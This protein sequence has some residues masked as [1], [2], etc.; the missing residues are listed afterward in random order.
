M[1][2]HIP[3][4]IRQLIV[5][6]GDQLDIHSTVFKDYDPKCDVVWM[7]E[8]ASESNYVWSSKQRIVL[9]LSAMRHFRALLLGKKIHL[10]YTELGADD[11]KGSITEQLAFTLSREKIASVIA[12]EP[13]EYRLKGAI[14]HVCQE[15][16]VPLTWK[17]DEHFLCSHEQFRNH[18]ASRRQLRM[19]FFYREMRKRYNI[20]MEG[21]K[22][23]GGKWNF[24]AS[25]RKSFGEKG[26]GSLPKRDHFNPDKITKGVKKLVGKYFST[27]PGYLESFRWPVTREQALLALSNF[28]EGCLPQFGK[29]QDAMWTN[30]PFLYHSLIAS[31][32]NLK[33]LNPREVIDAAEQ[34]YRDGKAS[35]ESVEGFIRQI[36]GWREYV[37]GVYWLYMP[38]YLERNALNTNADL[39]SFYWTGNTDLKCLNQTITQT[40]TYGYAHH[41]QRLMVTGLFALLYGVHPKQVHEWYLA[42]YVD[43]VEWVELPN[44]LGMSQYGDGGVMASKPYIATGKYIQRMSNYCA[45]CRYDPAEST[46]DTACPFTTLYWDFLIRH[47]D[48]L[49]TNNRMSMQLKNLQRLSPEKK[50]AIQKQASAFR[51]SINKK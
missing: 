6:L 13:G 25:N 16:G 10:I 46:G 29:Y 1:K 27:H 37:R 45:G 49:K 2:T 11:N 24:D 12:V 42:V 39:P 5:I 7:T 14:E 19:E 21:K 31:S 15:Q 38:D 18:A 35:I 48:R 36:L 33:L 44:T 8:A 4:R 32:L 34:A 17:E 22:P 9:F 51:E 41:I 40:L 26:P 28:I 30:E 3:H 43:A 50:L 20:L 47:Q 23:V